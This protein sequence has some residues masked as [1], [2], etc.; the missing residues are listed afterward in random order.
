MVYIV[1]F[2]LTYSDGAIIYTRIWG[3]PLVALYQEHVETLLPTQY[4]ET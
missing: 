2:L 4:L 1:L 3:P